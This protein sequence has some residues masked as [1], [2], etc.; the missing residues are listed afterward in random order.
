MSV[1]LTPEQL[2]AIAAHPDAP[3]EVVDPASS[4][5]FILL[6]AEDYERL[7]ALREEELQPPE[8]Y[9]AIDRAFAEGWEAPGMDDYDRYEELKQ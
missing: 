7:K 6:R 2:Q 5:K 9:P 3:L 1:T 8:A 4:R